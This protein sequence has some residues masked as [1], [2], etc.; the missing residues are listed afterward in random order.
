MSNNTGRLFKNRDYIA[1]SK[2]PL[3]KGQCEIDGVMRNMA[4]WVK[5]S[6]KGITY[7]FITFENADKNPAKV[8]AIPNNNKEGIRQLDTIAQGEPKKVV[9]PYEMDLSDLPFSE[10]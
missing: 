3:Y 6:Q 4:A 9:K 5:K 8:I 7:M 2:R 10:G 1:G